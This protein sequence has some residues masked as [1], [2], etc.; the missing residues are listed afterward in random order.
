MGKLRTGCALRYRESYHSWKRLVV[1]SA[2]GKMGDKDEAGQSR[3][4]S[5]PSFPTLPRSLMIAGSMAQ[6]GQT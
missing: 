2:C 5:K 3:I 6:T 1:Q 4:G